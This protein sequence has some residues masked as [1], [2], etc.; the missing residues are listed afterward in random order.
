[1]RKKTERL[2]KRKNQ[3]ETFLYDIDA[4]VQE[5]EE[6]IKRV[7][8]ILVRE[9]KS[10]IKTSDFFSNDPNAVASFKDSR[11]VFMILQS[12]KQLVNS[13]EYVYRTINNDIIDPEF[14]AL[15]QQSLKSKSL[16]SFSAKVDRSRLPATI[17]IEGVTKLFMEGRMKNLV[18]MCHS[19]HSGKY[20]PLCKD[21][22]ITG[23]DIIQNCI[24]IPTI[25]LFESKLSFVYSSGIPVI[26]H[27]NYSVV[28][29]FV[30]NLIK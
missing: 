9:L 28:K 12:F 16:V 4:I 1:M 7:S 29:D 25:N 26:F 8:Q 27:S 22:Y 2:K 24:L 21:V 14:N 10:L 30:K 13:E 17:F 6:V 15:V 11:K 20:R 18:K 3:N 5:S 23:Y 19:Q